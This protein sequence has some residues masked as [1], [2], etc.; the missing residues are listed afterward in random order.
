MIQPNS[1]APGAQR[2][3]GMLRNETPEESALVT[4]WLGRLR[5][6]KKAHRRFRD[7]AEKA[8]KAYEQE[9]LDEA[10]DTDE[11]DKLPLEPIWW[12][13]TKITQSAI[14]NRQPKP[15]VRRRVTDSRTDKNIALCVERALAYQ[16]DTTAFDEHSNRSVTEFLAA[17]L[18][19]TRVYLRDERQDVPMINP[20]TGQPVMGEDGQPVMGSR[21]VAQAT[22]I[23]YVPWNLFR[24]EP[25]KDWEDCGWVSFDIWMDAESIRREYRITVDER[26]MMAGPSE[27]P[28]DGDAGKRSGSPG[29]GYSR[30]HLV[31]RIWD[32]RKRQVVTICGS[33]QESRRLLDTKPDPLGLKGFFPC[34]RP[35][36]L[37]IRS[38]KLVPRPEYSY[39]RGKCEEIDRLSLRIAA[40]VNQVRDVGFFDAEFTKELTGLMQQPDGARVPVANLVS[41]FE[42]TS[43]ANVVITEDIRSK[44]EV[45]VQLVQERERAKQSLFEL[46]GIADIVRGATKASETATAQ[47]LKSQWANVRLTD[48][49]REV[50]IHFREVFRIQA[51][52]MS[53]K[54]DPAQLTEQT[55]IQ[56]TPD[57]LQVMRSDIG[58]CYAIDIESD[59]TI[60]Q[61]EQEDRA[62]RTEFITA[63]TDYMSRVLPMAQQ[64]II[65][66]DLANAMLL[67]FVGSFKHGRA[68]EEQIEQ[69][70]DTTAKLTELTQQV[71]QGQQAQQ[72]AQAQMQQ[73]QADMAKQ[74]EAQAKR[75]A[76]AE[77]RVI[78]LEMALQQAKRPTE[79]PTRQVRD[80]A[81]AR[82]DNA[83]A[84]KAAAEAQAL[85]QQNAAGA[86]LNGAW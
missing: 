86:L 30:M 74:V 2:E 20:I 80:M 72:Q 76:E 69:M 46:T 73:V 10:T 71:Q 22:P 32:K 8:M 37:N 68:L 48:K 18:G 64:G 65:P 35:M 75:A 83:Q 45:I 53:E 15:D 42:G 40:L 16:M 77:A 44:V 79:S 66:P 33:F 31:H 21:V 19:Q 47:Q 59:S 11:K 28:D 43:M 84:A 54:F 39:V 85:Q 50:S 51:E 5:R 60:A 61:D 3:V 52:L 13:N 23:E 38:G 55:G 26:D 27:E 56:V 34:P 17:G 14:F 29:A 12:S 4:T 78:E 25:C 24:W 7:Q 82:R 81:A 6:E 41:R 58:R 49:M 36:M 1:T 62:A 57:M 63:A 70:P 67:F 9:G